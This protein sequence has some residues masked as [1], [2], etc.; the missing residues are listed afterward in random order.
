MY[1][2]RKK[3]TDNKQIAGVKINLRNKKDTYSLSE[4]DTNHKYSIKR[5]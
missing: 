4:S 1:A 5:N 2:V 3:R